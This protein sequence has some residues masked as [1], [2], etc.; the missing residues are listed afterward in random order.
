LFTG[1]FGT[2]ALLVEK[3]KFDRQPM[4]DFWNDKLDRTLNRDILN[5]KALESLGWKVVVIWECE[6]RKT[7][8]DE[9]IEKLQSLSYIP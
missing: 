9:L 6:T 8:K 3:R 4:V 7:K 5:K 1:V 2:D